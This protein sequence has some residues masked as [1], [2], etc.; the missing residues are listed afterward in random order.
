MVFV[1]ATEH[2]LYL[3][4]KYSRCGLCQLLV[5]LVLIF[6]ENGGAQCATVF[7]ICYHR[8]I[9]NYSF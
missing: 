7:S 1:M 4:K 6:D 2:K 9:P 5:F 3:L 8:L